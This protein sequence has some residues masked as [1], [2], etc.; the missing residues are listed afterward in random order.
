M[1]QLVDV[2][3]KNMGEYKGDLNLIALDRW[4]EAGLCF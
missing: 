2:Q 4:H 3:E 1:W